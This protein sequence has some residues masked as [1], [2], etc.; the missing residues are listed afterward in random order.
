MRWTSDIQIVKLLQPKQSCSAHDLINNRRNDRTETQQQYLRDKYF[1]H[2]KSLL[3]LYLNTFRHDRNLFIR[4]FE[5]N[6]VCQA[7]LRSVC[8]SGN[9][10]MDLKQLNDA[11]ASKK[12]MSRFVHRRF[13]TIEQLCYRV[14]V[15]RNPLQA[16]PLRILHIRISNILMSL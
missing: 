12:C 16:F 15:A 7:R 6:N 13:T 11:T 2:S 3:V 4:C 10:L 8:Q 9:V 14:L 5:E 1:S